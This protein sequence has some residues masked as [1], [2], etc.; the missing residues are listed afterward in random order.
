MNS[1]EKINQAL[2]DSVRIENTLNREG[3]QL[4]F[5]YFNPASEGKVHWTCGEDQNGKIVSV[6][7]YDGPEGMERMPQFLEN[8]QAAIEMR[9]TL[10]E[11]GWKKMKAPEVT[12]SFPGQKEKQTLNR[13]QKRYL[14]KKLEKMNT[15]NP[16]S[17]SSLEKRMEN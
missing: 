14:K 13:K 7:Q 1:D 17:Q 9:E 11:S 12:F 4:P 8:K 2:A 3:D 10:I 16:F 5:G 6:F 15:K